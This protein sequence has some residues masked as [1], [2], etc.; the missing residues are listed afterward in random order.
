M[1]K[2]SFPF[3]RDSLTHSILMFAKTAH[4]P[5]DYQLAKY[6]LSTIPSKSK[7]DRSMEILESCQMVDSLDDGRWEINDKGKKTLYAVVGKWP[8]KEKVND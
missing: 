4:G 7:F 8:S 6:V 5:F 1:S 2:A 3:K